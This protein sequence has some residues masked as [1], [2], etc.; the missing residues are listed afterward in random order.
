MCD[1]TPAAD[2]LDQQSPAVDGKASVT[3]GHEDLLCGAVLD[4]STTP[5]VFAF[6]QD[7]DVNNVRDQYT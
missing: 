1:W 5:E 4:S 3:V 7:P 6:D 2:S